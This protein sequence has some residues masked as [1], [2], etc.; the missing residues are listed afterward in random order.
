MNGDEY[1]LPGGIDDLGEGRTDVY[2]QESGPGKNEMEGVPM[3]LL[4]HIVSGAS[5]YSLVEISPDN[6]IRLG[7]WLVGVGTEIKERDK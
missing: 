6:V 2:L 3:T 4:L 7:K 1:Y 5:H